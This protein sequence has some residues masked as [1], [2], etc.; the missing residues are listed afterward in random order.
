MRDRR[1]QEIGERYK[2]T[3]AQ[4][5]L[6]WLVQQENVIT[7]PKASSVQ[8]LT[9]NMDIFDFELSDGEMRMIDELS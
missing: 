5:T 1:L 4:V 2:K 6:R 8:H 3:P 9:E 7:I